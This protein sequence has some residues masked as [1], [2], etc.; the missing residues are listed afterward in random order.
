MRLAGNDG[1]DGWTDSTT[2]AGLDKRR[3]DL[4]RN[5]VLEESEILDV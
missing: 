3:E 5:R 4:G 1:N 2:K